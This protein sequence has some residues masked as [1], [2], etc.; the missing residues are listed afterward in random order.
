MKAAIWARVSTSDQHTENQ[1]EVLRAW[2]DRRGLE[3]VTEFVTEDSA[4]SKA[5]GNGKGAEFDRTRSD[6]LNGAR[7]GEYEVVLVWALDRLS[8]RGIEDT[9]GTLR[10]LYDNGS[11]VWS[12]QEGWLETSDPHMRELIVSVMAW[13]AAMESARRSERV[14]AGLARRRAK[15]KPMGGAASKRGPDKRKR[16]NPWA[17]GGSRREAAE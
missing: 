9:L 5:G 13:M 11:S 1:L 7:L 8:R 10:Q 16:A 2:A 15:G 3:V 14:K 12:H 4:W 6:L 17:P